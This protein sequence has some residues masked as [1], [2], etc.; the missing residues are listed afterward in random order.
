MEFII[1]NWNKALRKLFLL[2]GAKFENKFGKIVAKIIFSNN[3]L[4]FF[5][6]HT[7]FL[8]KNKTYK[9]IEA[10]F[11]LDVFNISETKTF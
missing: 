2:I 5:T 11:G 1:A 10:K 4:P 8:Q 6:F 9:H 3:H 7:L